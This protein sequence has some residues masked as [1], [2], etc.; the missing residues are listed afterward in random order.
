MSA[1]TQ[2]I[3]IDRIELTL[4][5]IPVDQAQLLATQ[6]EAALAARL[7]GAFAGN[8][9]VDA[10]AGQLTDAIGRRASVRLG[11]PA[12]RDETEEQPTWP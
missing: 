8:R 11:A 6:L 4:E 9:L 3:G 2:R 10:I 1:R 7:R 12:A 5:G